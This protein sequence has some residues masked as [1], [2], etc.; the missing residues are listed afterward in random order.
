MSEPR[1]PKLEGA[2][3]LPRN[4]R[5]NATKG[6]NSDK[7]TSNTTYHQSLA[8]FDLDNN[9][10]GL[11]ISVKKKI[12]QSPRAAPATVSD[13]SDAISLSVSRQRIVG[14]LPGSERLVENGPF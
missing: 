14:C 2:A 4:T 11:Q 12:T 8:C 7:K 13:T 5:E 1:L 3:T 10:G 9:L 6:K